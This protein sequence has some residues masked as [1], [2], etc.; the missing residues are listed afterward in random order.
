MKYMILTELCTRTTE[1]AIEH[2]A[3]LL[4]EKL[5]NYTAKGW[6]RVGELSVTYIPDNVVIVFSQMIAKDDE[7]NKT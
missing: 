1:S 4:A 6:H 3:G 7:Q 2:S 5:T